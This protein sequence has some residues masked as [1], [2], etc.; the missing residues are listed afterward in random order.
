MGIRTGKDP[1]ASDSFMWRV[2]HALDQHPPELA[3]NL[4]VTMRDMKP[5]MELRPH[6]MPEVDRNY[7]LNKLEPYLSNRLA[8]FMAAKREIGLLLQQDK[9]RRAARRGRFD[10]YHSIDDTTPRY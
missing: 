7:V 5:L 4:G 3:K 10:D 8:M 9:A 6:E 2:C 1:D